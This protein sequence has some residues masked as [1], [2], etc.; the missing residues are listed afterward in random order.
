MKKSELEKAQKAAIQDIA[1]EYPSSKIVRSEN[2]IIC[3]Y[4]CK[5]VR[6]SKK[7]GFWKKVLNIK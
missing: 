5:I 2:Q 6:K 7:R 1:D 3:D 4:D